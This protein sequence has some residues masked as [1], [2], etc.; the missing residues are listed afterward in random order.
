MSNTS[1]IPVEK[2]I[3]AL[4]FDI[5]GTLL[6]TMPIH[7]KACQIACS[8]H[9]FEFPLNFF[10]ETAGTPTFEVFEMLGKKLNINAN[11]KQIAIEKEEKYIELANEIKLIPAAEEVIKRFN[12]VLPMACGT[13]ATREIAE[14]NLKNS[15]TAH[16]FK[17]VITCDDIA[18]PKPD[19]ETFLKAA[20]ALGVSPEFCQ[21][22]EDGDLGIKAAIDA[23]MVATD[24]R[25]YL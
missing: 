16:Y 2:H 21:V 9:G 24:I 5:D 8:K 6:D 17:S 20:E 13:G 22:F 4:I 15:N 3:K 23:G 25:K 1:I 18:K 14:I 19:P 10:Y 11:F 7:Y 12:G